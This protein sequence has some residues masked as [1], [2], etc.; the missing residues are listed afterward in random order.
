[1]TV[2]RKLINTSEFQTLLHFN[3]AEN[4]DFKIQFAL[5]MRE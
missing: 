4:T 3:P 5:D 2:S 1:M